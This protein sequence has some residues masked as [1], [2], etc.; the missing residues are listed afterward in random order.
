MQNRK[1][2]LPC[3]LF[4]LLALHSEGQ[5][6]LDTPDGKKVRLNKNGTWQYIPTATIQTRPTQIGSGASAFYLSPNKQ[7][8]V[9]YD[10]QQWICDSI[11][12]K[13]DTGW[14][15]TFVSKDQAING[16]CLASRLSLPVDALE[17][18]VSQQWQ[19]VGKINSFSTYKDT[20]NGVPVTSFL[21][22]ME[23]GSIGYTYKGFVYSTFKG[24]FQFIVGTQDAVFEEDKAKIE[25]LVKGFKKM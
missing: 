19:Q 2:I 8:A 22:K 4:L 7:F 24:S 20:I 16:Y 17:Q 18:M 1:S 5:Y 3:F 13:K 23:S 11:Q 10:L 21:M 14:D 15:A 9:M 6:T 12:A 25:A